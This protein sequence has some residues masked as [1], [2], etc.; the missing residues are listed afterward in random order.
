MLTAKQV[1]ENHL[2]WRIE[3]LANNLQIIDDIIDDLKTRRNQIMDK[4]VAAGN[5]LMISLNAT[6]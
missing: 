6:K 4:Y 3:Y 1:N 2:L 5:L